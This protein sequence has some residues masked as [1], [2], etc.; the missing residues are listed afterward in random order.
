VLVAFLGACLLL[1]VLQALGGR[2]R[3]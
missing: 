3:R 2:A 1:L